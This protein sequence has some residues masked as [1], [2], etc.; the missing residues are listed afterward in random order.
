MMRS[1]FVLPSIILALAIR[2]THGISRP[3]AT[4]S[5]IGIMTRNTPSLRGC[6]GMER[7]ESQANRELLLQCLS[8][9]QFAALCIERM[10]D[11]SVRADGVAS[12]N[13]YSSFLDGL[14]CL[15]DNN[16]NQTACE[17]QAT[18]TGP[19]FYAL[20]IYLQIH[21]VGEVCKQ[22]DNANSTKKDCMN[23]M[24]HNNFDG[25]LF[26]FLFN[27]T[28]IERTAPSAE[29]AIVNLCYSVYSLVIANGLMP[30]CPCKR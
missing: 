9:D 7:R 2:G 22:I 1:H 13:E 4:R 12:Q 20:P 18:E 29:D 25:H 17:V 21:F 14:H 3:N 28:G 10:T 5:D 19:D 15:F 8:Q 23:S 16:V 26:G 6:D 24:L 11:V 27:Y 30:A